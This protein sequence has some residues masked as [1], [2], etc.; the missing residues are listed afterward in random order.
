[1]AFTTQKTVNLHSAAVAEKRSKAQSRRAEN[2]ECATG[3]NET[4]E[5]RSDPCTSYLWQ[6]IRA[7]LSLTWFH[8]S[9]PRARP[10][11]FVQPVP[12]ASISNQTSE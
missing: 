2:G 10:F 1:M 5:P 6:E 12:Q 4:T 8:S 7:L 11:R 9:A 3:D